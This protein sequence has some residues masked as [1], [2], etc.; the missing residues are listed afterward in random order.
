MS[1]DDPFNLQRF[2]DA[3]AGV[4]GQVTGELR[5]GRKH[6]HWIW[7]IFPQITG[8]GHSAMAHKYAIG[9]LAEACAYVDHPVLGARLRECTALVLEVDGK[10]IAEILGHPD[11]LKFHSSMSLFARAASDN[12]LF[13]DALEKY[14]L[15]ALDPQTVLRL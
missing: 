11:D 6:S 4:Y 9:S 5:A 13:L 8:L 7:F 12:R 14:F 10:T 3:Q 2:L 15:G 1:S